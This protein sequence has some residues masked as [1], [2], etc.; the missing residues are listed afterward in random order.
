MQNAFWAQWAKASLQDVAMIPED[1]IAR[2]AHEALHPR[3]TSR[4]KHI[5]S[6]ESRRLRQRYQ[7]GARSRCL[8]RRTRPGQS[9][10]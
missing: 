8:R 6:R 3:R 5:T 10:F 4:P 9:G 7:S 1:F 2:I